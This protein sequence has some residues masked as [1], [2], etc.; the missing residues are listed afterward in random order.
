MRTFLFICIASML[1]SCGSKNQ[2]VRIST[3]IGDITIEVYSDKAPITSANFLAYVDSGKYDNKSCFYRTVRMDNQPNNPVKIEVIQGGFYEDSLIEKYQFPVI[4]HETTKET[5]VLHKDGTISMARGPVGTASSEFFICIGD[6]PE[7]DF[8]GKRNPDGQGFAA[9]GKVIK[10]MEIVYEIQK[11]KDENQYLVK[12]IK[13]L[14]VKRT[15]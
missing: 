2:T 10:G 3:E 9:F 4:K 15:Y 5:G 14:S 7:L 8:D 11:Q 12:P 13:I 1:L 6:Q